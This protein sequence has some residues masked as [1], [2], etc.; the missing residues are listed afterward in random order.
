MWK[1]PRMLIIGATLADGRRQD[2]RIED[3]TIAEIG[4]GPEL[5]AGE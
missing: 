2:I 5:S 1:T 3:Q 4:N